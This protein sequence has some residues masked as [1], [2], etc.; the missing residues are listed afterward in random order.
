MYTLKY[1]CLF[2]Y[3]FIF[4]I[5]IFFFF[6]FLCCNTLTG[7][8]NLMA[9][10]NN[11]ISWKVAANFYE[12]L[13]HLYFFTSLYFL[14]ICLWLFRVYDSFLGLGW[15]FMHTLFFLSFFL[16]QKNDTFS[17]KSHLTHLYTHQWQVVVWL[18]FTNFIWNSMWVQ[19]ASRSKSEIP[20]T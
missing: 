15:T 10:L 5:F 17:Y 20:L 12:F 11:Y 3:C 16:G 18:F 8:H 1:I 6:F 9:F 2:I 13:S 14:A 7:Q 19:K 4:F